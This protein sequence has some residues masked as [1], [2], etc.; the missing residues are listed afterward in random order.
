MHI[1]EIH[2]QISITKWSFE[3][4]NNNNKILFGNFIKFNNNSWV[5]KFYQVYI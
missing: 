3:T 5:L 1:N 4:N 2:L